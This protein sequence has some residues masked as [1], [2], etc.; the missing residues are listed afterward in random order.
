MSQTDHAD[1]PVRGKQFS[2]S[3]FCITDKYTQSIW[4]VCSLQLDIN[5]TET[6][7]AFLKR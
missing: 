6:V 1:K 4:K 7:P 2:V 3:K 5:V